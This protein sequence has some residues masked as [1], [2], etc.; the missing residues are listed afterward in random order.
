VFSGEPDL[1]G[2]DV[3][4]GL[5]RLADLGRDWDLPVLLGEFGVQASTDGAPA[6]LRRHYEAIDALGLHATLWEYSRSTERWNGEALSVIDVDGSEEPTLDVAVRP[7]LRALAG[8]DAVF[9]WDASARAATLSWTGVE[10]GITE[11][12]LP[13]RTLREVR[14]EGEGACQARAGDRLLLRTTSTGPAHVTI[15]PD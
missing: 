6:Y 11:V 7:Y 8:D 4:A 1:A 3:E 9:S 12:V 5:T 13:S 15:R 14:V 2:V 10:D